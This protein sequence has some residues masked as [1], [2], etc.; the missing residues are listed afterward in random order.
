MN[1]TATLAAAVACAVL[2][3]ASAA[4]A[5][6]FTVLYGFKGG[7]DGANPQAGL[8]MDRNGVLYG[9]TAEGG[10]S[11]CAPNGCGTVFAL[12]PPVTGE[13]NWVETVLH[14]FRGPA[15]GGAAYP[16]ADMIMDAHGVLYGTTSQGGL[17][18]C[19][20]S[21][22]I[23][24]GTVFALAPPAAG[25]TL[26]IGDT[27]HRFAKTYSS[28]GPVPPSGL[29]RGTDGT[30]YGT[31]G[32]G[33]GEVFAV[34]PP[35]PGTTRSTI[36]ILY[37]FKGHDRG[38]G[39]LGG[40]IMDARGVLYGTTYIGGKRSCDPCR[41]MVFALIPPTG[42]TTTW[43]EEVLFTFN[44]PDG[45]FPEA[46]LLMDQSGVLYGTTRFGGNNADCSRVGSGCGT[47]FKLS[48]PP[49]GEVRWTETVLYSFGNN[50]DADGIYPLARLV[51]DAN[52]A[53]YSTTFEGG[54]ECGGDFIGCGTIFKLSP[55]AAGGT[56]W[57]ETVLHSFSSGKDG[58]YP[59][60]GLLMDAQGVLYGTTSEGG[61]AGCG[62]LGCGT[63]FK[64]VP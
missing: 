15:A 45:S 41:G 61:G 40:L 22:Q 46:G 62:R 26:W 35:T 20:A 50:L 1:R 3:A 53:L 36:D 44:K 37:R 16:T 25:E 11:A 2:I 42:G 18:S 24:C 30:L 52:G 23:G 17:S 38:Y 7:R 34:A 14:R 39:P 33:A 43:S 47:V 48:P 4:A 49:L 10:H 60:A 57:A 6:Q 31:T 63:V 28:G 54:G 21:I 56:R 13:T 29:I 5:A 9:T 19:G 58:A 32:A 64:L 8:I 59:V 55:P 12:A 51:M 27:L